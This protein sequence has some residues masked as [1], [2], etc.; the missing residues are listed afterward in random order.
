[1]ALIDRYVDGALAD[2]KE[3]RG[4]GDA[5][6]RLR[7]LLRE[8]A[9]AFLRDRG[10]TL[11]Q[12]YSD[13]TQAKAR[14]LIARYDEAREVI[15]RALS[16][17]DSDPVYVRTAMATFGLTQNCRISTSAGCCLPSALSTM[18]TSSRWRQQ[19]PRLVDGPRRVDRARV[20]GS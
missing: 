2:L 6:P 16:L 7:E 18:E 17:S 11:H 14:R 8:R 5:E 3:T 13:S 4:L 10:F 20:L 1:M 12:I 9:E 19:T 15:D